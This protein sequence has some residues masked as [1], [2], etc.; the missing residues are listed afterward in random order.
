MVPAVTFH[1]DLRTGGAEA[2][3][4]EKWFQA[5][6]NIRVSAV[7]HGVYENTST[8]GITWSD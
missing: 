6:E 3:G 5:T 2:V 7:T 4:D 8:L 1:V